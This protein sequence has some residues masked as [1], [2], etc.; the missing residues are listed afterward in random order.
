MFH[1]SWCGWCKKM[2]R[3]MKL[4]NTITLFNNN[5]VI[6]H[7]TVLESNTNKKFENPGGE[8]FLNKNGGKDEG[9]PFWIILDAEGNQLTN[10]KNDKSENL[11]CP[12]TLKEVNSFIGKLKATSKL[13][14]LELEIIKNEF[15]KK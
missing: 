4:R 7:I 5:Y 12:A 11:G 9:L 6:E 2:D 8:D 15:I 14:D 13:N 1:A 10:S 3:N